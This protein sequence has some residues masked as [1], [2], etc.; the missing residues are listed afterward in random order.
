MNSIMLNIDL[1]NIL[2]LTIKIMGLV[3]IGNRLIAKNIETIRKCLK[4][5]LTKK[6]S[7]IGEELGCGCLTKTQFIKIYIFILLFINSL[8]LL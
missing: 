6:P 2:I 8:Q 5:A 7:P 3:I 4:I 1:E